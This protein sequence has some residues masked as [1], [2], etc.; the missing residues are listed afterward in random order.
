MVIRPQYVK[1]K[2]HFHA[3]FVRTATVSIKVNILG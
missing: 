2:L 3:L 1:K